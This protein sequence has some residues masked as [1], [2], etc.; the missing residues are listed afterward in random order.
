MKHEINLLQEQSK[1]F[2]K[3]RGKGETQIEKN[4]QKEEEKEFKKQIK[5]VI[6]EQMKNPADI[7]RK[8]R[9]GISTNNF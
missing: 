1:F 9:K 8:Y 2:N 3:I 7:E 5:K 4:Q 6:L